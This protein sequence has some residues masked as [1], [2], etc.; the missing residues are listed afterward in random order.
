[1]RDR[2]FGNPIE[3]CCLR[4][5]WFREDPNTNTREML[6]KECMIQRHFRIT[7]HF[8]LPFHSTI[9]ITITITSMNPLA[10]LRP[11]LLTV[12]F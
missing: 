6:R 5:F 12:V 9:T 1:M 3:L 11:N 10:P 4:W 7:I 2:V 8:S